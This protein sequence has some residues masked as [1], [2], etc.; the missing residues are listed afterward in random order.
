MQLS[1]AVEPERFVQTPG[2][3]I[4]ATRQLK[5]GILMKKYLHYYYYLHYYLQSETFPEKK[6]GKKS[7]A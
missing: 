5:H 3:L 4:S 6:E 7:G 2:A 1:F